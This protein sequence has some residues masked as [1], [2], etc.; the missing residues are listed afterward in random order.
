MAYIPKGYYLKARVT[1]ESAI[2]HAPP[3]VREVWDYLLSETNHSAIKYNGYS[4]ER[5]QLF[6][7]TEDIRKALY[8]M[9]GWRKMTYKKHECENAMKWLKK[10]EM[11]TTK[12]APRGTV[13]TVVKYNTYQNPEN[14]ESRNDNSM[15][16]NVLPIPSR[17]INKNVRME[18]TKG[19]SIFLTSSRF[20]YLQSKP[21]CK[22]L[23]E[24]YKSR[25]KPTPRAKELILIKLH[26]HDLT[27]AI[28]MLK[29]SI[30]NGWTGIFE[31]DKKKKPVSSK[32]IVSQEEIAKAQKAMS[33]HMVAI[34]YGSD[35][36]RL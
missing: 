22:E 7:S 25:K 18:E 11:I 8:W 16:A 13:I 15:K 30:E 35:N 28:E 5:G 4:I 1:Q 21:F 19:D 34:D 26:D 27:V 20:P 6:R 31:I 33:G 3:H 32:P 14:Y 23:E 29:Q 36:E 24:Y 2:A 12:K 10:A 17:P 9:V